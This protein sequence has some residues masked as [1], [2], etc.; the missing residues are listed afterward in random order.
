MIVMQSTFEGEGA[1]FLWKMSATVMWDEV[2]V[3]ES[4]E[5]SML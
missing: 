3:A 4:G 5:F 1:F 2:H